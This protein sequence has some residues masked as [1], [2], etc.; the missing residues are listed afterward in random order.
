[1][2]LTG[3]APYRQLDELPLRAMLRRP[4]WRPLT[5]DRKPLLASQ[6]CK[7]GVTGYQRDG[8]KLSE[9]PCDPWVALVGPG[10]GRNLSH[11]LHSREGPRGN[12]LA[13]P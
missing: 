7:A 2:S 9:N 8:S 6:R 4:G 10:L 12:N 11:H 13:S 5:G 3:I 1:M